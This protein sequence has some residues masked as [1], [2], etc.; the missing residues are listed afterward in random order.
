MPKLCL[1][2]VYFLT[3]RKYWLNCFLAR[4]VAVPSTKAWIHK[5]LT[6]RGRYIID[7]TTG[8]DD[9]ELLHYAL[10]HQQVG[11]R[12]EGLDAGTVCCERPHGRYSFFVG[13]TSVLTSPK[14]RRRSYAEIVAGL[15]SAKRG[16]PMVMQ[17]SC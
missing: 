11:A 14:E 8:G 15:L 12:G 6:N 7:W 1:L 13:H 10:P 3:L 17:R 4:L 16:W 2:T 9:S 5:T